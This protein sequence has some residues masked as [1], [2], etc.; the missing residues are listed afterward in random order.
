MDRGLI[1]TKFRKKDYEEYLS[2]FEDPELNARLGP[3]QAGDGWLEQV[4][5][6]TDG[7]EYSVFRDGELVA[8]V[9]IYY[10]DES[11]PWYTISNVVVKPSLRGQGIGKEAIQALMSLPELQQDV[12]WRAFVD[13]D[14]ATAKH[15]F[16][17]MGWVCLS[18]P[19]EDDEM[20]MFAIRIS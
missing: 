13:V 19:T 4:L 9:G 20:F 10:P 14:N 18:S 12:G 11:H 16:E 2:W 17:S 7:C 1:L 6:Q 8:E 5:Q 3:M 15:F